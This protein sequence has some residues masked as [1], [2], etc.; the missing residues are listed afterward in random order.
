MSM[1]ACSRAAPR[2]RGRRNRPTSPGAG[3]HRRL[4]PS[5]PD[6][7]KGACRRSRRAPFLAW[8]M[9]MNDHEPRLF[10]DDDADPPDRR[11]LARLHACRRPNG[12]TRR[13]SPPAPGS[14]S[15]GRT[16]LPERDLPDLI[17]RY[18][19]SVGGVN[20]DTR[21]LSRDDHPGVHP[22]RAAE[23]G[24]QRRAG[25]PGRS[26][27]RAAALAAG[28]ARLAAAAST[29]ASCCSRW[30]R[31]WAGWSRIWRRCRIS[32]LTAKRHDS[33]VRWRL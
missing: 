32:A 2:R 1:P 4:T 23:S 7:S 11:G 22:R 14:S 30:R 16:S 28:A 18:N 10:A 5:S 13:I 29:A 20:S 6:P 9:T 27:Q 24:G 17:R 25:R 26:G 19:E 31:G 21:G 33:E 15:S 8:R 12:P 3:H